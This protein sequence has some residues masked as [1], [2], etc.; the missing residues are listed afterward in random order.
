VVPVLMESIVTIFPFLFKFFLV[1]L[2]LLHFFFFPSNLTVN[3]IQLAFLCSCPSGFDGSICHNID[4]CE[5]ETNNCH[6]YAICTDTIGSFT[7]TCKPGYSGNGVQCD[8]NFFLLLYSQHFFIFFFLILFSSNQVSL[9]ISWE[10]NFSNYICRKYSI[11]KMWW[12]LW[13]S[14][15]LL[16]FNW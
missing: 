13:K 1:F 14:N 5:R 7:C 6:L 9:N 2:L 16:W 4:E 11:R 10:C 15:T 3:H 12:L 8:R